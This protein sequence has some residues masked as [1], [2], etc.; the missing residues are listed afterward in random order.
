MDDSHDMAGGDHTGS[1]VPT[2]LSPFFILGAIA[3]VALMVR[4]IPLRHSGTSWAMQPDS[5]KYVALADG[6]RAGC[7]FAQWAGRCG[8]AE[9]ERTPGY[10]IF[11]VASGSLRSAIVAQAVLG[12]A[13][14]LMVGL[15]A[16][17][18]WG[19]VVGALSSLLLCLDVPSIVIGSS[20]VSEALF[21]TIL[22]GAIVLL[23]IGVPDRV[24]ERR[25][26]LIFFAAGC[27]LAVATMVRPIGETLFLVI[28]P[29][30]LLACGFDLRKTIRLSLLSLCIPVIVVLGWSY[31][32]YRARGV[33]TISS[34]GAI[35][36]YDYREAGVIAAL[37]GR[38]QG[39]VLTE[40]SG[41]TGGWD[42]DHP[43]EM[44]REAMRIMLAHPLITASMTLKGIAKNCFLPNRTDVEKLMNCTSAGVSETAGTIQKI[45]AA[46]GC[47]AV[48][49]IMIF[50]IIAIILTWSG[51]ALA[52]WH[53]RPAYQEL[54]LLL[55]VA[56]LLVLAA[57]GPEAYSRFRVPAMPMIAIAA[58]YGWV[59]LRR[60]APSIR[61]GAEQAA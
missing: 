52:L 35:Q 28:P 48:F 46:I 2:G 10:P 44:E 41:R 58:S 60:H 11:L 9:L 15:Y 22:T 42:P 27:V 30:L 24:G 40:L 19:V 8:R 36:L 34:Q 13:T 16:W 25:T 56:A 51:I 50:Q 32:N 31:R 20:L 21:T 18:R 59:A 6:L 12:V 55:A 54:C 7:G 43:K 33:W 37:K 61:Q 4:L 39:D 17:W 14:C 53:S 57:A 29:W 23:L 45:K 1:A 49:T 3:A 5:V 38:T 26:S 47:P